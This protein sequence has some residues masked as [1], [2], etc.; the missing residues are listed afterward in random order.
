VNFDLLNGA[1]FVTIDIVPAGIERR[2]ENIAALRISAIPESSGGGFLVAGFETQSTAGGYGWRSARIG[3]HGR[4][5]SPWLL[6]ANAAYALNAAKIDQVQ[7][8]ELEDF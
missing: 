1:I 4:N 5:Q 8:I 7:G 3:P 2:R 6:I